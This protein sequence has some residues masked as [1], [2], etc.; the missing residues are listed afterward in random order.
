[1]N[2][3]SN[4]LDYLA[5]IIEYFDSFF[6]NNHGWIH[7]NSTNEKPSASTSGQDGLTWTRSTLPCETTKNT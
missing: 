3:L 6:E 7:R 2:K 5:N 1:M 4:M